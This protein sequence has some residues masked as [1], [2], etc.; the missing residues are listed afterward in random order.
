MIAITGASG[1]I[2]S[3]L[4]ER[5]AGAAVLA[6]DIRPPR[7]LP[8]GA[9]FVRHDVRQP[10]GALFRARGVKAVIHL[11]FA[12]DPMRDRQAE[13]A[14]N[15]LGTANVLAACAEARVETVILLS[16]A[17]V[18][19]A[20]PDNPPALTEDAP[21]RGCPGFGYVEDKLE[22]ERM[23]ARYAR[24]HPEARVI[25]VRPVV[26]AGPHMRNYLS[27]SLEKPFVFLPWGANPPLQLIHEQDVAQALAT[28][29]HEGPSG[30]YNLGA[31]NPMPFQEVVRRARARA[32]ALPW[33]LLYPLAAVAWRMGWRAVTEAPP[34]LL[35]YLRWPW[36]VDGS[37]IARLTSFAYQFDTP[38]TL[39]D[40]LEARAGRAGGGGA[41]R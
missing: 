29:L 28:L 35:H 19:G 12:V 17:T 21:L 3:R 20:Y 41:Y 25:L 24:E 2:G 40:Y 22:L 34:A 4:L 31:P 39:A 32:V 16:S 1:Y 11:A 33:A 5:L 30:P 27:R 18:Y 8:E 23:A 37:R 15:V 36:V 9:E 13:R 10:M 14:L 38:A 26:V 7:H 6:L